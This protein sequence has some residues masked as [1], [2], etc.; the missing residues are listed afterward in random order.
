MNNRLGLTVALF[1]AALAVG[2]AAAADATSGQEVASDDASRCISLGT[3]WKVAEAEC[4]TN[5][6]LG[7][8]RAL[9]RE[10]ETKCN[11]SDAAQQKVGVSK[12]ES[13][14]R[15]CRKVTGSH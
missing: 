3:D 7:R 9:A 8:A 5:A 4:S 11:S 15:L 6:N 1:S 13:A 2:I 12:F 10:A 14:L